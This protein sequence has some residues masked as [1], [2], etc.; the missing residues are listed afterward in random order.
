MEEKKISENPNQKNPILWIAITLIL[1]VAVVGILFW[2]F[3]I[4]TDLN[5]LLDEKEL[6]RADLEQQLNTLVIEHEKVKEEYGALSDSLTVK[7]SIIQANAVEIKQLLNTKWEYYKVKKKLE[8]LQGIAQGYVHQMDSL[9][10]VNDA[11]EQE[12]VAIKKDLT[13]VRKEKE[14]L[15]EVEK[16][17]T[18]KVEVASVLQ[19][20]NVVASGIRLRS[21][22]KKEVPTTKARKMEKVKVCFILGANEIAAA[23]SVFIERRRN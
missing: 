6:Q 20:H 12:N 11:L 4:K 21:G 19:A 9:Y 8:Q 2:L 10:R 14:T 15:E 7:D 17:L 18:Q 3:S 23:T 16:E 1:A 5:Q 22:G 13:Q